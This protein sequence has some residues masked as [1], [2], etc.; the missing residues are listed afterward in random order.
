MELQDLE[1]K[2][3]YIPGVSNVAA[4][5]ISRVEKGGIHRTYQVNNVGFVPR[6]LGEV[7]AQKIRREQRSNPLFKKY[8]QAVERVEGPDAQK[9]SRKIAGFNKLRNGICSRR[10]STDQIDGE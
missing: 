1:L 8:F 3:T 4:D 5:A 6:M 7:T 9:S 10:I 2:I